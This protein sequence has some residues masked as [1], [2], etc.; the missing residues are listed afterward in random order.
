M[1]YGVNGS[2]H[3]DTFLINNHLGHYDSR[4]GTKRRLALEVESRKDLWRYLANF[5]VSNFWLSIDPKGQFS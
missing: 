4:L 3:T 2:Q 1:E 5:L